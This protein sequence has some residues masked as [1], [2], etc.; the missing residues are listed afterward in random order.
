MFPVFESKLLRIFKTKNKFLRQQIFWSLLKS[1]RLIYSLIT[2]KLKST[3]NEVLHLCSFLRN[4]NPEDQD[5]HFHHR[6]KLIIS[7]TVTVL[8]REGKQK[9]DWPSLRKVLPKL[10]FLRDPQVFNLRRMLGPQSKIK[11]NDKDESLRTYVG[12]KTWWLGRPSL[13]IDENIK[14]V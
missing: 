8:R 1:Y 14:I 3:Y 2:A 9:I 5:W 6:E 11:I 4:Y 10:I 12:R 7:G 13:T